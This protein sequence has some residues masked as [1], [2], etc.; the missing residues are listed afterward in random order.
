MKYNAIAKEIHANN[1][2]KGWWDNP[3]SGECLTMLVISELAEATE[4]VRAKLP[5][6]CFIKMDD[7]VIATPDC[8]IASFMSV[9]I[10]GQQFMRKPEGEAVE[11]VDA[12]IRILDMVGYDMA[13]S[14]TNDIDAIMD[15]AR[16]FAK[17]QRL[18]KME[19]GIEY[20]YLLTACLVNMGVP[21][22]A[23]IAS[24]ISTVEK[25]FDFMGWDLENIIHLKMEYNLTR[26]HRH[27]GK[28]F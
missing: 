26:E 20:H 18:P 28:A 4:A 2:A 16:E 21:P 23:R 6:V 8:D 13:G 27:G 19:N 5:P 7:E 10:G 24:F 9:K 14:E 17:S 3:R 1:V 22:I 15:E 25:Y 11:I 12:M